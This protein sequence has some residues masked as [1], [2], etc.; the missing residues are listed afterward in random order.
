M[1]LVVHDI[2]EPIILRTML[3]NFT[4]DHLAQSKAEILKAGGHFACRRHNIFAHKEQYWMMVEYPYIRTIDS[5]SAFLHPVVQHSLY[6][7]PLSLRTISQIFDILYV[8]VIFKL[9]L[10]R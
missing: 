6:L 7:K 8:F 1:N 9:I 4:C 3:M 10:V 5:M 2:G